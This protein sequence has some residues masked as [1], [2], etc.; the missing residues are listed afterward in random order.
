MHPR[1]L[2]I[3]DTRKGRT[4]IYAID[5]N[6]IAFWSDPERHARNL[7][8]DRVFTGAGQIFHSDTDELSSAIARGLAGFIFKDLSKFPL[9]I[10]PPIHLE[11]EALVLAKASS[12]QHD[13]T[14]DPAL[15]KKI[16]EQERLLMSEGFTV[17]QLR[18]IAPRLQ[19]L[20]FHNIGPP[21]EVRRISRVLTQKRA[22]PLT[23]MDLPEQIEDV[24]RPTSPFQGWYAYSRKRQGERDYKD[25]VD[26]PENEGWDRRLERLAKYPGNKLREND[27]EVLA[28][29]EVWNENLA[30]LETKSGGA[31][32]WRVLLIT[33]DHRIFRAASAYKPSGLTGDFAESF[34]R[35]PRAFLDEEGVLRIP[36]NA[37]QGEPTRVASWFR[38]LLGPVST[39]ED[40]RTEYARDRKKIPKQISDAVERLGKAAE[41]KTIEL[42]KDWEDFTRDAVVANPPTEFDLSGL[43]AVRQ[44]GASALREAV[45]KLDRQIAEARLQSLQNCISAITELGFELDFRSKHRARARSVMPIFFERW[46]KAEAFIKAVGEWGENEFDSTEYQIGISQLRKDDPTDYAFYLAHAALFA[47]RGRWRSGALLA[48][49]AA[50]SIRLIPPDDRNGANGREAAYFEAACRRHSAKAIGD[51][52][53]CRPLVEQAMSI[54]KLEQTTEPDLDV[55]ADRFD[56]ELLALRLDRL[57]FIRFL[58]EANIATAA[59][60]C[61]AMLSRDYEK[62]YLKVQKLIDVPPIGSELGNRPPKEARINLRNRILLN[63]VA[64]GLMRK[65]GTDICDRSQF[66]MHRIEELSA[67]GDFD[68]IDRRS[69]NFSIFHYWTATCGRI[70]TTV[71]SAKGE[72]LKRTL[73]EF[74]QTEMK[75]TDYTVFPYDKA[76]FEEMRM[77]ADIPWPVA[78]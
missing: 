63:L 38:L 48:S 37:L 21:S 65:S 35:H 41:A 44:H 16:E 20:L 19:E 12:A 67:T 61:F 47:G 36:G 58:K 74:Y 55:A 72:Q 32:N 9:L 66:A 56:A 29:L 75:P 30:K 2:D 60:D 49:Q 18:E 43:D 54:F 78:T 7:R 77:A 64:L 39:T 69:R 8:S 13:L 59:D 40:E 14:I 11:I 62:L 42:V 45:G 51:L 73:D 52:A 31:Q 6:I 5:T 46:P 10:I 26:P 22:V 70:R 15:R 50:E 3:E 28:R 1:Q 4:F 34:I 53:P 23:A 71:G 25:G 17:E 33:F 27:A 68:V 57:L 76:R 24:L